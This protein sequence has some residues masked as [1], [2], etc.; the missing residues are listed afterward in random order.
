M[1]VVPAGMYGHMFG[2]LNPP[3]YPQFFA[4]G[5][6]C[7]VWDVD[8]NSYIDL[9]CAWGPI[10]LGD[11][12]PEIEAAVASHR[13]AGDCLDGPPPVFV[14]LAETFVQSIAHADWAMFAK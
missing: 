12:D 6:G 1:R 3:S 14:E 11:R 2:G 10:V 13:A 9:M 5:E 4:R 8:G 7:R